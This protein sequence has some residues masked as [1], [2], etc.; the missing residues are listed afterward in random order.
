MDLNFKNFLSR[1]NSEINSYDD[2]IKFENKFYEF[3]D[4]GLL[5][6]FC[7]YMLPEEMNEYINYCDTLYN[8]NSFIKI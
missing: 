4:Y 8:M 3:D 5:I 2:L 6:L 1:F 7:S